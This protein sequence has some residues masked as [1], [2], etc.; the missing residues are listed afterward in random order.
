MDTKT[1]QGQRIKDLVPGKFLRLSKVLPSGSLEAR[2]LA[3]G[4]VVLYWRST[5]NGKTHRTAIGHYDPGAPPKKTTPTA[6]G[7]SI[8]AAT[9]AAQELA[10][11]HELHKP[12]G[13]LPALK[14]AEKATKKRAAETRQ[15]QEQQTLQNLL[16]DYCGYLEGLGRSAHADARSIFKNHVIDAWP[17]IA[18]LPANEVSTE[19]VTDIMRRL[20]E[21]GKGRT[22]NKLR[23]YVRAA[24]QVAKASRSKATVPLK[25]KH[26]NVTNNPAADTAPDESANKPDKRPLSVGEMRS[27]WKVIKGMDGF[28]GAVLRLHLLTGG[29]R[30][31]QLV[32]LKTRD[33]TG[34]TIRL[35]DGKGRPGKPPRPHTIPLIQA[36]AQA[37]AECK[38]EGEHALSTNGGKTPLG[39]TTLSGWAAE[40]AEHIPDFQAKRLRSGVETLLAGA[41]VS[42]DTRGRLQSHGVGG[43]QAAHYDAYEYLNEKRQALE[44]LFRLLTAP[45]AANVVPLKTG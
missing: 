43:V 44:T 20:S 9:S 16:L 45:K 1:T 15:A 26:Y 7:Y 37:L 36:A 22:S 38:P 6:A 34:D 18:A 12:D 10:N 14:A 31:K 11:K 8:A 19:Q 33:V 3:N 25:F 32:A 30:I 5:I 2:K 13:G 28:E 40:A 24:Y 41:G 23:S 27:Y 42:K 4:A 17:D 39:A 21:Q 35:F 29:Q